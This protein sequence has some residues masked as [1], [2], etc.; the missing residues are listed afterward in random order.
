LNLLLWEVNG[1]KRFRASDDPAVA[2]LLV[3]ELGRMAFG[4]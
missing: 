1:R 4:Q 2:K 3:D